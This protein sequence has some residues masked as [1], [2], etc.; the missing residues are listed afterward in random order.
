MVSKLLSAKALWI[1]VLLSSLF[2]LVPA[3]SSFTSRTAGADKAKT[4]RLGAGLHE[5]LRARAEARLL[6]GD[7]QGQWKRLLRCSMLV[8]F[9]GHG[10]LQGQ[11]LKTGNEA[12]P[13]RF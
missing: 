11:Y 13:T 9:F 3:C 1:V 10:W 7:Q 8:S 5:A 4:P 12:I 6:H 2:L